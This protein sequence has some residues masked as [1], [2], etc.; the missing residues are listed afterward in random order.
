MADNPISYSDLIRPDDSILNLIKQLDELNTKYEELRKKAGELNNSLRGVSGATEEG[1]AK[2]REAAEAAERLAQADKG[3]SSAQANVEREIR[4]T[5]KAV[6]EQVKTYAQI[7]S[8]IEQL[9]GS[10]Q[11]NIQ[12]YRNAQSEIQRL[13]KAEGDHTLEIARLREERNKANATIR[14]EIRMENAASSSLNE[15]R[16]QLISVKNAYA[17][18]SGEMRDSSIGEET[19]KTIQKLDTEVSKIEQ[20]MGVHSRNVGNYRSAFNGLNV[21]IQQVA[22]ELPSL[23][24]GASMFFLAISN[25]LPILVDE[26]KNAR[27]QYDNLRASG[28]KSTPVWKQVVSSIFSWQTALVAVITVLSMY[29]QEIF[30]WIAGLFKAKDA[31]D[32]AALSQEIYNRTLQDG[33]KVTNEATRSIASDVARVQFLTGAIEDNTRSISDRRSAILALQQIVP[34]YHG[35][36]TREGELIGHNTEVIEEY[37][38]NLRRAATAQ[39]AFNQMTEIA[40]GALNDEIALRNWQNGFEKIRREAQKIYKGFDPASMEVGWDVTQ[41]R[42]TGQVIGHYN[43]IRDRQSG[44]IITDN[45]T[46]AQYNELQKIQERW[47][48]VSAKVQQYSDRLAVANSRTE[49]LEKVIRETGVS[50][51]K[52]LERSGS[53]AG[54]SVAGSRVASD[55]SDDAE[56]QEEMYQRMI[57]ARRRYE[58]A[59]LAMQGDTYEARQQEIRYEYERQ[60]EDLRHQLQTEADMAREEREAANAEIILLQ[61]QLHDELYKLEQS[62]FLKELEQLKEQNE[63]RLRAVKEGTEEEYKLR[64]EQNEINRQIALAENRMLPAADRQSEKDINAAFNMQAGTITADRGDK[65]AGEAAKDAEKQSK[66]LQS[67][68][69][70]LV[71]TVRGFSRNMGEAVSNF[72]GILTSKVGDKTIY[73]H[74]GLTEEQAYA[75]AAYAG[76]IVG[77]L[78]DIAAARV[79]AANAAVEEAEKETEAARDALQVELEARRNGYA[80]RVSEARKE[81][82]LAQK[83]QQQ[84]EKEQQRALRQQQ[85]L[86]SIAQMGNLVTA[87]TLIWSLLG[88]P[89]AIPAIA[90]MWA[91]FAATKIKAA[92]MTASGNGSTEQYGEGTVELLQGGSHQ[93]GD[94]IDLGTKPDGTRRRAEGGEFFAVINKRNSRRFRKIIPDVIRSFND[95]SFIRKYSRMYE[96]AAGDVFI[97]GGANIDLSKIERDLSAIRKGSRKRYYTDGKGRTVVAYKNLTRRIYV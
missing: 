95:G 63:L 82:Q 6:E 42:A 3:L 91:S 58:D 78:Q 25:N 61:Q 57:E 29:G 49:A 38:A 2:I 71:D 15:M 48:A 19:L 68:Y 16:Q 45:L 94:D 51:D 17:A 23:S 88:F 44:R 31:T 74:L 97:N 35:S 46:L 79:E 13:S 18:M 22:R 81:L 30:D 24:M 12:R 14:N 9:N 34:D 84:A 28:Q 56:L 87:S 11:Q 53:S 76:I 4:Q 10:L 73:E 62:E 86:Q 80:N 5:N 83:N 37:I 75:A 55:L 77:S 8:R 7:R 66:K 47:D 64:L 92:T 67:A 1:R 59:Q 20:S 90:A 96:N 36:L 21:S 93:S 65:I 39:A 27:E 40:E 89:A 70:T 60:I 85:A 32:K 69:R 33:A 43:Q 50:V 52:V 54:A 41:S 26:L 72:T